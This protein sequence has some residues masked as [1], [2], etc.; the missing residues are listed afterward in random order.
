MEYQSVGGAF[1][2]AIEEVMAQR[3]AKKRQAMLDNLTVQ[4]AAR[5]VDTEANR[6]EEHR[7][8]LEE[9][10]AE[11][12]SGEARWQGEADKKVADEKA[13]AAAAAA[14]ELERQRIINS[15]PIGSPERANL[16]QQ[17]A[18]FTP[19]KPNVPVPPTAVYGWNPGSHALE[20]EGE[21]PKGSIIKPEAV[22][23]PPSEGAGHF[24]TTAQLDKNGVPIPGKF[25]KVNTHTGEVSPATVTGFG[26]ELP[27][28][29]AGPG[30]GQMAVREAAKKEVLPTLDIMDKLVD[31]AGSQLGPRA[32]RIS[33]IELKIGDNDPTISQLAFAMKTIRQ[34]YEAGL[35][36]M[37]AASSAL[38]IKQYEDLLSLKAT[39]ENLHG[40]TSIIRQIL[41]GKAA[42]ETTPKKKLTPQ[43]AAD[44]YLKGK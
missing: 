16:E 32:G 23:K 42:D 40:M 28:T 19:I 35:G 8:D 18:G 31:K 9:R 17:G 29:K 41:S 43:E 4:K 5:E 12:R 38:L 7:Q 6:A 3:E 15:Y 27:I 22:P 25:I 39:P 26:D 20:K 37:R 44:A 36:G 21:V 11:H 1:S 14:K 13:K 34:Q 24:T 33:D 30:A 2:N 10:K